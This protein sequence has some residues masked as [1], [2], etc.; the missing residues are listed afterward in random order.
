MNALLTFADLERAGTDAGA[1]WDAHYSEVET[2]AGST[3]DKTMRI[4]LV[5]ALKRLNQLHAE[6]FG[7]VTA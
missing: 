4:E 2:A 3:Q 6:Y 7:E 1:L 5:A